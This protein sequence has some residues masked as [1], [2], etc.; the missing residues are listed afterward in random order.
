MSTQAQRRKLVG[1]IAIVVVAMAV[2]VWAIEAAFGP[3]DNGM[4]C[5][6]TT[7]ANSCLILRTQSAGVL[8]NSSF[9]VPEAQ[10]HGAMLECAKGGVGS[11]PSSACAVYLNLASGDR[12]LVSSY[13]LRPQAEA[14]V[15]QINDYL[16]DRSASQLVVSDS[17]ITPILL[18]GLLPVIL[19]VLTVGVARWRRVR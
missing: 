2:S 15:K 13:A 1:V 5:E 4:R 7:N 14:A 8:G 18:Y 3:T 11:R 6:R 19:V 16:A 12:Q 17:I 10:I 9:T